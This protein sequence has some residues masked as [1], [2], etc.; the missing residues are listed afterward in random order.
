MIDERTRKLWD[1]LFT[2]Q[3]IGPE[4]ANNFG[5]KTE[6]HL[7]ALRHAAEHGQLKIVDL[8]NIR[9]KGTNIQPFIDQ[10]GPYGHVI[11]TTVWDEFAEEDRQRALLKPTVAV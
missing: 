11:F 1:C 7:K 3:S 9:G 6:E 2:V 10:D 4:E 5:I 8:N